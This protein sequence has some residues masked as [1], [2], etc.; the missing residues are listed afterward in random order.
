MVCL[1]VP[2]TKSHVTEG[3]AHME[4]AISESGFEYVHVSET[5]VCYFTGVLMDPDDGR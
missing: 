4:W 5:A 3:I 1:H 2:V